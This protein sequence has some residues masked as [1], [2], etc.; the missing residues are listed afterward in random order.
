MLCEP[1]KKTVSYDLSTHF[2]EVKT[3]C[4][5]KKLCGTIELFKNCPKILGLGPKRKKKKRPRPE[6]WSKKDGDGKIFL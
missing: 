3:T 5:F 6:K 4:K 1:N 2:F